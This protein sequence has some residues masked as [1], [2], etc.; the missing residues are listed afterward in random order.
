MNIKNESI[1]KEFI[2]GFEN[3]PSPSCHASTVVRLGDGTLVAAWFGGTRESDSDV[4]IYCSRR[5]KGKGWSVPIRI[6]GV[7]GVAHWNPVLYVNDDGNI[8]LYFKVGANIDP[9]QT[10]TALS[11]DGG[12]SFSVPTELV[13]GDF[14]GRGP[15]KNKPVKLDDGSLL[16][17][18]SLEDD[19]SWT[20]WIDRFEAGSDLPSSPAKPMIK[21][22]QPEGAWL[23]QPTIW[24]DKESN[25]HCLMR[26]KQEKIYRS[27]SSDRGLSWCEA[28][29]IGVPNNCSGLDLTALPD[30]KIVLVCNPVR[31][32]RTPLSVLVSED[33][34]N[35]FTV[36]CDLETEPGE[37]SYP[38]VI[39]AGGELHITYTHRR[40][41]IVYC[42]IPVE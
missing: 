35:T 8:R 36:L 40:E 5:E 20:A 18:A 34:G 6:T 31:R 17:P 15:V 26:S 11:V 16:C 32:G 13:P 2:F 10:Y 14:G 25:V 41:R 30:G 28:Y 38:A 27:D 29:P 9:W 12:K 3:A 21:I 39:Y 37:Y 7:E 33:N 4:R 23:I 42:N 19:V 22:P 1:K 24:Q